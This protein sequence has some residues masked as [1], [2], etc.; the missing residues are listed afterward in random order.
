VAL[1]KNGLTPSGPGQ[2]GPSGLRGAANSP[3]MDKYYRGQVS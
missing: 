2:V 1:A 3:E